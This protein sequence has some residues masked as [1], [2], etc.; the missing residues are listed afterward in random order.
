[1]YTANTEIGKLN[2]YSFDKDSSAAICQAALLA[3]AYA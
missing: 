2:I 1:M 3:Y